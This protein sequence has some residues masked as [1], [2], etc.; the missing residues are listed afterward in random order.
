MKTLKLVLAATF[1]AFMLTSV[2][3]ADG[4]RT[5]P[6]FKKVV[7]VT[8]EK[9][10]QD[11]NLKMVM[12]Q[13]IYEADVFDLHQY[14]YVAVVI[15]RGNTYRIFGTTEQWKFFFKMKGISPPVKK[16]KAVV[17]D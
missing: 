3:Y 16:S 9:A 5:N 7:N 1:V 4:F 15:Y 14:D 13:Q 6:K 12:Y 2:S 11:P 8:F 10:I 17:I